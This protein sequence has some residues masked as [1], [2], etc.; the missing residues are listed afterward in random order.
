MVDRRPSLASL[1]RVSYVRELHG[2]TSGALAA[3]TQAAAAGSV[4]GTDA[5]YVRTR[6]GDLH[7]NAGDLD[8]EQAR[9]DADHARD[10]G[11]DPAAAVELARAALAA[12][13]TIYAEDTVGWALRQAGD[14]AAALSHA[15][16]AVRL[17]TAD[18]ALW[19]HL[20]V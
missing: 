9:F 20:A 1:S 11:A 8:L 2:D 17:G 19:Y 4:A 13:P 12:R 14:S 16:A 5:A 18:A 7:L 3:M 6:V 15:H 10:L